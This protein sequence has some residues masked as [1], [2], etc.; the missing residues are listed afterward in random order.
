[1]PFSP[2]E[3]AGVPEH[4]GG[5][6]LGGGYPEAHAAELAANERMRRSVR[7][8]AASGRPVVGECGG[9]MY[10]SKT[11]EDVDGVTHEMCGVIPYRTRMETRL[12][13]GYRDALSLA[14]SPLLPAGAAIRGHE[15]HFST[16]THEPTQPAYR[17]RA[18]DGQEVAE[19]YA[20]GNVLASYLHLHYGGFPAVA[21]RLVERCQ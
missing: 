20:R 3:D 1:M 2:L 12:S 15:F 19:G 6:L 16:L 17:W 14:D 13:L 10:L 5:L 9:L 4:V 8:F 21:A 11:L 18:H 7:A